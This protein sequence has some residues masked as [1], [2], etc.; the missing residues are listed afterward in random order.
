MITPDGIIYYDNMPDLLYDLFN[1][2]GL[3]IDEMHY[4]Y[5]SDTTKMVV[6]KDKYIKASLN[7]EPIYCGRNEVAFD[8]A[9]NYALISTLFCYYLDKC[10]NT[11]DGDILQ[12]YISHFID[13]NPERDMQRVAVKTIGRGEI[14]SDYFYNIYLAYFDC[15]FKIAGYNVNL[16]NFDIIEE[17]K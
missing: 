16:H 6:F 11:D 12:G 10:Q 4:L 9:K 13:D 14:S 17:K 1:E 7:G 5:D 2:I 8:P 3:S 15:I